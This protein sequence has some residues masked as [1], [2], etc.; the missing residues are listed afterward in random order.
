MWRRK[1]VG[2]GAP[3]KGGEWGRL[4]R[5]ESRGHSRG[6]GGVEE[7]GVEDWIE[8]EKDWIEVD[9][10]WIERMYSGCVCAH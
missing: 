1:R 4:W 8:V 5:V 6:G 3:S 2:S 10:D 7:E 9:V